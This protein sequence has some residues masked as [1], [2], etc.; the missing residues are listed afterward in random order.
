MSQ[1]WRDELTT[2]CRYE[3]PHSS[4]ACRLL[5]LEHLLHSLNVRLCHTGALAYSSLQ[6]T[7]SRL[8]AF[9]S[10]NLTKQ[11]V[12]LSGDC[13]CLST[14]A[15]TSLLIAGGAIPDIKYKSPTLVGFRHPVTNG[16]AWFSP[17]SRFLA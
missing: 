3:C 13:F 16:Q 12:G 15:H 8:Q 14:L 6:E 9:G 11:R 4:T 17:G 7:V 1:F 10:W 2:N 5:S